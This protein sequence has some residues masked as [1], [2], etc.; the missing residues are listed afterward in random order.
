MEQASREMPVKG[1]GISRPTSEFRL[2]ILMFK[3]LTMQKALN[4]R[5]KVVVIIMDVL[6]LAELTGCIYF[7]HQ[8]QDDMTGFF[9]RSF[10]PL[11]LVTVIASRITIRKM[12]S[13]KIESLTCGS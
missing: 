13:P 9:L 6:L 2:L 5:Q 12:H 7:G 10:I 4:F 1:T 11:A 3:G 8:Y